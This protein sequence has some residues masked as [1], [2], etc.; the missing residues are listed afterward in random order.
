MV[1]E[2]NQELFNKL[3][4]GLKDLM[5]LPTTVT[6]IIKLT[7]DPN[8]D[9]KEIVYNLEKD[10]AMVSR[11]L[12]LANSSY[13]GFSRQIKTISHAV[14][15]LGYNTI[16]NMALTVSTY[17]MFKKGIVSYALEKGAIFKHSYAVAVGAR[18]I[19]NKAGHPNPEEVYVM[20]LLHD[21]GKLVLDEQAKDKFI[22]VIR[23]FSKGSITFLEAEEQVLGFNHGEIGSKVAEK[24]NLS[25]EIVETIRF[26][27]HPSDA[28]PNNKS[29]HMVHLSD[30]IVEM[31]GIGLGYDGLSYELNEASFEI[32][33]LKNSCMEE[34]MVKIMD[35]MQDEANGAI[36]SDEDSSK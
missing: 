8:S 19:A 12:K 27:H 34:L 14:V 15:C 18:I 26:H 11:V 33:G 5:P 35:E 21:V 24:W 20:G 6:A 13:Y 31:M 29:V 22:N 32:L 17:P 16:K 10:Q 1:D 28:S 25:D 4:A 30:V 2:N 9:L 3:V 23:L 36:F 7:K